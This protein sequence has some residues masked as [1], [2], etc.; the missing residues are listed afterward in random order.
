MTVYTVRCS[1]QDRRQGPGTGRTLTVTAT[2]VPAAMSKAAR[3][4][5]AAMGRRERNDA[6]RDGF[7]ATV[8]EVKSTEE[9]NH[10]D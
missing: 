7:S 6:R 1:F 4:M 9:K 3:Q 8:R 5:W 10:V 2:N